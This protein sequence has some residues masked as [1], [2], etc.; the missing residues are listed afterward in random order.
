MAKGQTGRSREDAVIKDDATGEELNPGGTNRYIEKCIGGMFAGD[1]RQMDSEEGETEDGLQEQPNREEITERNLK[2][3]VK[4][5]GGNIATAMDGIPM[6]LV[7]ELGPETRALLCEILNQIEGQTGRSREDAVIKDDATGEEL[8][9]GGTNRYIEKCI[10]GMFAGDRR[11]MD[12][13]EGET[14][15]GLQEQPNREEITER[16]LKRA[17]KMMGGNIATAMD[18]I[19]MKLVKELGPETRALL[20][21]ILNQIE[22]KAQKSTLSSYRP[23]AITSVLYSVFTQII[24]DRLQTWAEA[25]G[26]LWELRNG[27]R[28]GRRLEDNLF[29]LTQAI[30]IAHRERRPLHV[31]L[32]DIS[33]APELTM[34]SCGGS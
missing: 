14:E 6:K 8:N 22:G 25:E 4:M 19:P 9:P 29:V 3:A 10:G 5:M 13:E 30:E 28:C 34:R 12:S 17:V 18:G 20:C 21:E 1:R 15:D 24:R 11:Q 7:K 31:C 26:V 27:F 32:L 2:R 23:T 33:R 16:N